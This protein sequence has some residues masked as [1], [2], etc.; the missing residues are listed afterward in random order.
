[1][2]VKIVTSFYYQSENHYESEKETY[3]TAMGKYK[4]G[5]VYNFV[6][7]YAENLIKKGYVIQVEYT[8][9]EWFSLY[10]EFVQLTDLESKLKFVAEKFDFRLNT[11][12]VLNDGANLR[13]KVEISSDSDKAI[14]SKIYK[15][16]LKITQI[17]TIT[18][19][20][21]NDNSGMLS[22]AREYYD[23]GQT[24][25]Y[26]FPI[27][28]NNESNNINNI[29]MVQGQP[30]KVTFTP[31]RDSSNI[32]NLKYYAV[33][34]ELLN[35]KYIDI[36]FHLGLIKLNREGTP[37]PNEK[38]NRTTQHW[39]AYI[40]ICELIKNDLLVPENK[41]LIAVI[42]GVQPEEHGNPII[43]K[44]IN[45]VFKFE[46]KEFDDVSYQQRRISHYK[47]TVDPEFKK[48]V[49]PIKHFDSFTKKISN[50]IDNT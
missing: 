6:T 48:Q 33:I 27:K 11:E 18:I 43:W 50:I 47:N 16:Y 40:I 44:F 41:K 29:I 36:D 32:R 4:I 2:L 17:K 30:C 12:V 23:F 42:K 19:G 15:N 35:L 25:G 3:K 13:F 37:N 8:E 9:D 39:Q 20:P 24:K 10:K 28:G 1:M 49:K 14:F 31:I 46:N 26:T 45:S 21:K 5:D 38:F 34:A 7:S 22:H